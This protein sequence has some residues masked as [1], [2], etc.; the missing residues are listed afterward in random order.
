MKGSNRYG[1]PDGYDAFLDRKLQERH[2]EERGREEHACR[3]CC[4]WQP[5]HEL[6]SLYG[7]VTRDEGAACQ[8]REDG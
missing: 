7:N 8:E 4:H 2:E 5:L 1:E 3:G 6:C